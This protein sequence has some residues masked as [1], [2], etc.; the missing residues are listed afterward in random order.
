MLTQTA[1]QGVHHE[2]ARETLVGE[3]LVM[4]RPIATQDGEAQ[5]V[6][7][8]ALDIQSTASTSV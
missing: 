2:S 5:V 6:D 7:I 1:Q 3:A 4:K 8:D